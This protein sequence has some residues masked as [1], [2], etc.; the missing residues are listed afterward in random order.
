MMLI[1]TPSDVPKKSYKTSALSGL[2]SIKNSLPMPNARLPIKPKTGS[3][4]TW[5]RV[6]ATPYDAAKCS[7]LSSASDR[8]LKN[9]RITHH[10]FISLS[11]NAILMTSAWVRQGCLFENYTSDGRRKSYSW[12][13]WYI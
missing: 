9:I 13:F 5:E 8:L 6:S 12:E 4:V 1:P 2:L 7:N 11:Q 3:L 10:F